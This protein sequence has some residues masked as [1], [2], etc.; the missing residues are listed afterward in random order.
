M[1][2]FSVKV[3]NRKKRKGHRRDCAQVEALITVEANS[4][5]EAASEVNRLAAES[6]TS[7]IAGQTARPSWA[8]FG[9]TLWLSEDV[10]A[11]DM[12]RE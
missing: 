5:G 4:H 7:G 10:T 12:V 2:R 1:A 6:R 8:G 9:V 11:A 3:G